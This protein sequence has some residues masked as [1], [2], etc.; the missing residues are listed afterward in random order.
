VFGDSVASR[1]HHT[2]LRSDVVERVNVG[3]VAATLVKL[4]SGKDEVAF[5]LHVSPTAFT[6]AGIQTREW[7]QLLGFT[8][9]MGWK[10][11]GGHQCFSREVPERYDLQR[12]ATAFNDGFARLEKANGDFEAC[13]FWLPFRRQLSGRG[14]AFRQ[15]LSGDG[16][17]VVDG[18]T[19]KSTEDDNFRYAL[20]FV[21]TG[22]D[23]GFV[24]HYFSGVMP[25]MRQRSICIK[26]ICAA[27]VRS[28]PDIQR[29][30][31]RWVASSVGT[32]SVTR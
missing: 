7:L 18:K 23:K 16:H 22:R 15:T 25:K 19:M 2:A 29:V 3:R 6:T 32:A 27:C 28:A 24:T 11:T 21:D 17:M 12:F 31:T 1:D 14:L 26:R 8:E 5:T 13:G 4:Q 10:F 20:T 30:S 9:N